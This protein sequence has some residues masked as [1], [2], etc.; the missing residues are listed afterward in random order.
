MTFVAY[1]CS[2]VAL[3]FF[4]KKML[5]HISVVHWLLLFWWYVCNHYVNFTAVFL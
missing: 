2:Y 4:V 5:I 1:S 3:L